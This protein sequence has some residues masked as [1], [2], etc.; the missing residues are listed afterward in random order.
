VL[1]AT[2]VVAAAETQQAF[3]REENATT[4][5][6]VKRSVPKEEGAR[7]CVCRKGLPRGSVRRGDVLRTRGETLE[8]GDT[9]RP[10]DGA[11]GVQHPLQPGRGF[12]FRGVRSEQ[13]CFSH[14]ARVWNRQPDRG[15]SRCR[16]SS[17]VRLFF[18]KKK[19]NPNH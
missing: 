19:K 18:K 14:T 16:C 1:T 17:K 11:G 15:C 9:D 10:R 5:D 13:R 2:M 3:A 12:R 4:Q 6:A 7:T 8:E